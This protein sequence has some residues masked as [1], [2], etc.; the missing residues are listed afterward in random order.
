METSARRTIFLSSACP[1][2]TAKKVGDAG[3]DMLYDYYGRNVLK[4][5]E[6]EGEPGR[7]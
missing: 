3:S 2:T 4:F 1:G 5:V 6:G 7:P